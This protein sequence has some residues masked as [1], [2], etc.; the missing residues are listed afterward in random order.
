MYVNDDV[1]GSRSS[2]SSS[3]DRSH[4]SSSSTEANAARPTGGCSTSCRLATKTTACYRAADNDATDTDSN[5]TRYN[6]DVQGSRSSSS[7]STERSAARP[8]GGCS[9]E[10]A[11]VAASTAESLRIS[12][13]CY[14]AAR[15]ARLQ[16]TPTTDP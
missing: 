13:P 1:Q 2:S 11:A 8:K 12:V 6:D 16:P 15:R 10:E 14:R 3:T 9:T 5:S 4:S 7:S